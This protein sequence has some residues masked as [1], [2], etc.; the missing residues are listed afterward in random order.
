ML[1]LGSEA[2]GR[3]ESELKEHLEA[4]RVSIGLDPAIPGVRL[5]AGLLVRTLRRM[6]G[7]ITL[8]PSDVPRHLVN[9]IVAEAELIDPD[10]P[11]QVARAG[12]CDIAIRLAATGPRGT[13]RA[14]PDLHGYRLTSGTG[15]LRQRR[16]ASALGS[17]SVAAA[18]IWIFNWHG[19]NMA[20]LWIS[21]RT[22]LLL[23]L[24][25]TWGTASLFRGHWIVGCRSAAQ[26]HDASPAASHQPQGLST[27]LASTSSRDRP[28]LARLDWQRRRPAADDA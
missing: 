17:A 11:V 28:V 3:N 21:G 16:P 8:D 27:V 7:V 24:F 13:L 2:S 1:K 10:R 26:G 20:T 12:E 9:R 6:P 19:I 18:A 25:A 5:A 14:L 22:A 23:T 4:S 15:E